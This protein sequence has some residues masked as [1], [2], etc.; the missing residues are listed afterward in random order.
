MVEAANPY[1]KEHKFH[2]WCRG[3][4]VMLSPVPGQSGKTGSRSLSGHLELEDMATCG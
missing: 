4:L 1:I 3:K 2:P